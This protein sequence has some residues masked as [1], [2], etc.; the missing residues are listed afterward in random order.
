MTLVLPLLAFLFASLLVAAVAMMMAPGSAAIERRLGE[1]T[2]V[3]VK[4]GLEDEGYDHL[5]VDALKRIG[6]LAPKSP[7][8][9]PIN[10]ADWAIVRHLVK[11]LSPAEIATRTGIDLKTIEEIAAVPRLVHGPC[12]LNVVRGGKTPDLD[13]REAEAMGYK[14]AIVPGLLIK[15]VVGI[16]DRMLSEL[17]PSWR[18][19]AAR[20]VRYCGMWNRNVLAS[21][22]C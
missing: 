10:M 22:C 11:D 2:G 13:L 12:L 7:A 6:R 1:V 14:L 20:R 15:S 19:S 4:G 18:Q 21:S 17:K 3:R 16:C 8:E 9:P 5:V